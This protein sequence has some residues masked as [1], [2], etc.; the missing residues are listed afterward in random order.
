MQQVLRILSKVCPDRLP[1]FHMCQQ[2]LTSFRSPTFLNNMASA[3]D[4]QPFFEQH[5]TKIGMEQALL[6]KFIAGGIRTVSQAAYAATPPGQVLTDERVTALCNTLGEARPSLAQLTIVK[7]LLFESQTMSLAHLKAN[8]EQQ[9]ESAV[10]K[11]PGAERMQRLE[12]QA[13]RLGGLEIK[14]DLEPAFCVYDAVTTQ[15]E[16]GSLRYIHPSK[17]PTRQQEL[18]QAKP[19]KELT[20]DSSGNGLSIQDRQ[21]KVQAQLGTEM[22]TYRALQRRGLAYDLVGV[23]SFS[24]HERWLQK[25]FAHMS[26]PA[27]PGYSRP[28]LQ[29]VLRADRALWLELAGRQPALTRS[30]ANAP[31]AN[32]RCLDKA[33]EEASQTMDVNFHFMPLQQSQNPFEKGGQAARWRKWGDGKGFQPEKWRRTDKGK[34][35]WKGGGK[36]KDTWK[37]QGENQKGSYF[38]QG[39]NQK[40]SY[41]NKGLDNRG[42]KTATSMPA[43]LR[44]GVPRD[45]SGEP[46]CYGFGLGQCKDAP[47][48]GRCARGRHVCCWP[49][50]FGNHAFIE[51]KTKTAKA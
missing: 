40:G 44:G 48:G 6:D 26:T 33:F 20:L 47:V 37:G 5:A 8:I 16:Q 41:S 3:P 13:A 28:G 31:L 2:S 9:P 15:V 25:A 38:G 46:I 35:G 34:S 51:H 29:Q 36:N 49:G 39:E 45:D 32:A 43:G 10:R 24:V 42:G 11:L 17:V 23:L 21:S 19:A 1:C 30:P 4:S 7:R 22:A 50:C 18:A 12:L 14:H 27:P